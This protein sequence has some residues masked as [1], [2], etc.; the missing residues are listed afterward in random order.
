[1]NKIYRLIQ[2]AD[3]DVKASFAMD[4]HTAIIELYFSNYWRDRYVINDQYSSVNILSKKVASLNPKRIL[5]IG[6]GYNKYKVAIKNSLPDVEFVGI[7][8]YNDEADIKISL[9][10]YFNNNNPEPFDVVLCLGSINF[11]SYEKIAYEID[12]VDK[13][14][15]HE[16]NQFW[17]V[18]PGINHEVKEFPLADLIDFYHWSKID[19]DR[20]CNMY[21]YKLIDFQTEV[22]GRGHERLYFQL[23]KQV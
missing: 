23:Y 9:Y 14:T 18:N 3:D 7:D 6:C 1:M 21:D 13:L 19:V 4:V 8:P 5:D 12:M 22:N 20:M 11:G 2:E 15:A 16:G 17:R 10:D